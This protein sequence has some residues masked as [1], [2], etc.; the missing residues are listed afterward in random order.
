[1]PVPKS[2]IKIKKGGVEYVSNV[3][4]AQYLIHE[5][6]RAALRDTGKLIRRRILDKARKL[7][8]M[9]RGKRIPHAFQFWVRKREGDLLIGIKHNTW[10]GADQELGTKN[11][12]K[13]GLLRDTTHENISEI[14]KVQGQYLSA[15]E[16]ELKAISL[17]DEENE[18]DNSDE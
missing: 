5:L 3:D 1:M 18:G 6:V 13:R 2:V 15:I 16:D 9:K 8:G 12:P 10:Y 7:P 4:R 17:I 11:Q 14:Q